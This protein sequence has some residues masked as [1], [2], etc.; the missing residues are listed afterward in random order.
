MVL[1]FSDLQNVLSYAVN[2]H[3]IKLS[4]PQGRAIQ[5][6]IDAVASVLKDLPNLTQDTELKIVLVEQEKT[7]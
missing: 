4:P 1:K 3:E 7:N 6:S 2:P 5:N